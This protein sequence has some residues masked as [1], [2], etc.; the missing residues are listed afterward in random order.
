MSHNRL[1]TLGPAGRR[2]R[3][4]KRFTVLIALLAVSVP[5]VAHAKQATVHG[6]VA[7]PRGDFTPL[8]TPNAADLKRFSVRYDPQAGSLVLTW[9]M[10]E[11]SFQPPA[12]GVFIDC[13]PADV[14][15]F[16]G[17]VPTFVGDQ[18]IFGHVE[19]F[20]HKRLTYSWRDD[21]LKG[22]TCTRANG[23]LL[24]DRGADSSIDTAEP[25]LLD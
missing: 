3:S 2:L 25:L 11:A 10:W 5:G 18:I 4:V 15:V 22:L 16:D 21:G 1:L 9:T 23:F 20:A 7:D 13:E 24:R 17:G 8:G 14:V 12:G 19:E 6:S